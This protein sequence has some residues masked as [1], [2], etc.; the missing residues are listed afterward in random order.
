M[1][2]YLKEFV[3]M[4]RIVGISNVSSSCNF[5]KGMSRYVAN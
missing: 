5:N 3:A 2:I 4:S 1:A